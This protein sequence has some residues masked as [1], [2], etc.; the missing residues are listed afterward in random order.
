MDYPVFRRASLGV[1][2]SASPLSLLLAD[3]DEDDDGT[4]LLCFIVF[5]SYLL[6]RH[7]RG[8]RTPDYFRFGYPRIALL[9]PD[10]SA[11]RRILAADD[12]RAFVQFF[13]IPGAV[14][15]VLAAGMAEKLPQ[16]RGPAGRLSPADKTALCLRYMTTR[17][18]QHALQLDFGVSQVTISRTLAEGLPALIS[19]MSGMSEAQV[20]LPTEAQMEEYAT[21]I[22][23]A[24]PPPYPCHPFAFLDGTYC[25]TEVPQQYALNRSMY[26]GYKRAHCVNN[27][28]VFAPDG[29]ILWCR[30]NA[31][32]T[33]TD[34]RMVPPLF[35][36]LA[37]ST[38]VPKKY[39]ILAD[40]GYHA[41]YMKYKLLTPLRENE[42]LGHDLAEAIRMVR[43]SAWITRR[44]SAAEWG[45]RSF[46]YTF[47]RLLK[48]LP[49]N[50]VRRRELLVSAVMLYNLRVRTLGAS[51][52]R[53][54]YMGQL[55]YRA[56]VEHALDYD[57]E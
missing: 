28:L 7:H 38:L 49:N 47:V 4:A 26:N 54:V 27:Q 39:S 3:E 40:G 51:E 15:H 10:A 30:L 18:H 53:T 29:T 23:G 21:A 32:G 41:P 44:R 5:L 13:A 2:A 57:S 6:K 17:H 52:I 24:E 45:M 43:M 33:H 12:D 31:P 48:R 50:V 42:S 14:F 9:P 34:L 46:K 16:V 22:I 8:T 11:W 36:I 37:D 25:E 1:G 35:D 19:V 20:R 55:Q 56:E